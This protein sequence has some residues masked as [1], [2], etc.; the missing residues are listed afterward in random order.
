MTE[1]EQIQA[2]AAKAIRGIFPTA[3]DEE[4]RLL[5]VICGWVL[6]NEMV[7]SLKAIREYE[8][9][10]EDDKPEPIRSMEGG[11]YPAVY[12]D[13]I[14][15]PAGEKPGPV[16]PTTSAFEVL[17]A[18][19][20]ETYPKGFPP[21]RKADMQPVATLTLADR[22]EDESPEEWMA[23]LQ[24]NVHRLMTGQS[25]WFHL[26]GVKWEHVSPTSEVVARCV[27]KSSPV[28]SHYFDVI[29]RDGMQFTTKGG[30]ECIDRG[31]KISLPSM[32]FEKVED[33]IIW[34]THRLNVFEATL[35]PG[36]A[37]Q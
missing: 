14:E 24:R 11:A 35:P 36:Q 2:A 28:E 19:S 30:Y 31:G 8:A 13:G 10:K 18:E 4:I 37:L 22:P 15:W 17:R 21:P 33:A 3:T 27:Y 25:K 7:E 26:Y 1:E 20:S 29:Q 12:S 5:Y 6:D 16:F 32:T 34:A 9:D 23:G